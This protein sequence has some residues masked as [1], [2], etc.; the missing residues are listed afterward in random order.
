MEQQPIGG[1][2]LSPQQRR[3][4][5][6]QA[7][8]GTA[9]LMVRCALRVAAPLD[10]GILRAALGDVIARHEIL[11]TTFR[12][13]PGMKLP[14][15]VIADEG[16]VELAAAGEEG[17]PRRLL[18]ELAREPFDPAVPP[19]LRCRLAPTLGN[20]S[21]LLLL[22]P[23]LS[24][25]LASLPR[26]AA[27]I[28]RAYAARSGRPVDGPAAEP[29]QYAD[30][31]EWQNELL[32][33]EETEAGRGFWR[34]LDLSRA[35]T[36]LPMET[37]VAEAG[38][39]APRAW[40]VPLPA[41][42]GDGLAAVAGRVGA[43]PV[44]ILLA[45]WQ[46]FLGRLA[47]ASEMVVGAA[48]EGRKFAELEDAIGPLVRILPV[49][50]SLAGEPA[51][52][53]VAR[54]VSEA[55]D[56]A[57]QWQEYFSWDL[58][59]SR[60]A[61]PAAGVPGL[62]F[63]FELLSPPPEPGFAGWPASFEVLEGDADRFTIKLA[64]RLDGGEGL[65]AE[66]Q[67]DPRRFE[68]SAVARLADGFAT[69]LAAA[70][71]APETRAADLDLLAADDRRL[72]AE[73]NRTAAPLPERCLHELLSEQA[74]RTPDRVAVSANSRELTYAELDARA[75]RLAGHL[76]SLGV[77]P[78]V[79]VGV[80]LERSPELV[81]ALLAVLKAGGAYVP[82]D[83]DYPRE[84]LRFM[85]EDAAA[86]LLLTRGA[87]AP[88]L[89]GAPGRI[90]EVDALA[91]LPA[92]R[93]TRPRGRALPSHLAYVLYTSGS[94]GRPK[95]VMIP[96]RSLVSHMLWMQAS[97]PLD[98]DD[99]VLQRTPFSFDA[100]VWEFYA[101]LLAGACLVL[102]RPGNRLDAGFLIRRIR[103]E[104]VT[105]LQ[106]VPSLLRVLLAHEE[107]AAC[108]S[109][110]RVFSGGEALRP[111]LARRFCET[112]G[113]DLVNLYGPTEATIDSTSHRT[114]PGSETVPIG[115]PIANASIRVLDPRLQ[116]LP[117]LVPGELHIAGA[118]LARGYLDRPALTAGAFLPDPWSD[119]PGG[120]MYRTGDLVRLLPD[121][122][123]EFL[124][125]I[126]DQVKL[127][128][129][130]LE[131]G[132]IEVVL[133][134]HPGVEQAVAVVR[135]DVPGDQRLVAY[136]L[137]PGGGSPPRVGELRAFLGERL[138][139]HMIPATFV[140][141][142]AFP[143]APN[144][145]VDRRQL[146]APSSARPDLEQE[147]VAPRDPDEEILA[148][149][150]S[151]VLG[152]DEIGVRDNFLALGAD[153][154]RSVRVVALAQERGIDLSLQQ[155][156]QHQT[157]EAL[158]EA[159]RQGNGGARAVG[160]EPFSLVAD[161]DLAKLPPGLEDAYPL[162]TLQAGMLYHMQV[163]PA[164]PAYHNVTGF[165]L[166]ARFDREAFQ[167]AVDRAVARH[168][169]LRTAFDMTT[170]GE[171]LQLV[172]P[173]ARLVVVVEDLRGLSRP[174]QDAVVEA[175]VRR[176]KNTPFDL[177]RPPLLRFFVHRL[178]EETFWFTL[179]EC[180]SILDGWSLTSI[181]R[182]VF[183][184]QFR[185]LDGEDLTDEP[186]LTVTFRDFVHQEIRARRSE[187]HR[188]FWEE[189]L[190]GASLLRLPRTLA[191]RPADAPSVANLP[192]EIGSQLSDG[193]VH[194]ARSATVPLKSVCLAAHLKFLAMVTGRTDI[195]TGLPTNGRPEHRDGERIRGLFIN[196]VPFRLE[197]GEWS[198]LDLVKEAF[199]AERRL[200]PYRQYPLAAMR[201]NWDEEP[202]FEV[203]FSFVH[204]HHLDR[205]V[206]RGELE[207]LDEFKGWEATNF[208][209]LV[210]FNRHPPSLDLKMRLYYLP[211][212]LTEEQVTGFRDCFLRIF[213]AMVSNPYAFHSDIDLRD[214]VSPAESSLL[215]ETTHVNDLDQDFSF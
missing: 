41:A 159:L 86:P 179:T 62:P 111:E 128:G 97:F 132:E 205:M 107:F 172:H 94:T 99:R 115:R 32:E 81:L 118:G 108:T 130:R 63:A 191:T 87:L 31:A 70:L 149:I 59:G 45:A 197:M 156:F 139:E 84:R 203:L 173:R 96:H 36:G 158:A 58:V 192:V 79:R 72:L 66:L 174:Q 180:H 145:K 4:W 209:L 38:G 162:S 92:P 154:I 131:L 53:E 116:P 73:V 69:F 47:G 100:S 30:L 65:A 103:E 42:A 152:V 109:L 181:L 207:Y 199:A 1:F 195:L 184:D 140:R 51:F 102:D 12:P 165:L 16:I 8:A 142:K 46:C 56:E 82:L 75:E 93:G 208:P 91:E 13:L 161:A 28:G 90:V 112:L 148:A 24:A 214:A 177:S 194:L 34:R 186:P 80:C 129:F 48:F 10:P 78:D 40:P 164:A 141:L 163:D 43:P 167:T 201:Q 49:R 204:F 133:A 126:N 71:A 144:G 37:A 136:W 98:G 7:G 185:L 3:L 215:R 50:V 22:L 171:P 106:V 6:L 143:L 168:A 54:R 39:F 11:R 153:S 117:A 18:A 113:A 52:Q 127:R 68:E 23:A 166:R 26:L 198:W 9:G 61:G 206:Q 170:Y 190:R 212:E 146:P 182:E 196:T 29:V 178:S 121:G 213:R 138:P 21:L 150:W 134:G 104:G 25:D 210:G 57:H 35:V 135:E 17:E 125:R 137:A 119:E 187:E 95:G 20:G 155:V 77:G 188:A 85:A 76:V 202:L 122:S 2:R 160:S 200:L 151:E 74:G 105:V 120:R 27:E 33:G 14:V 211:A 55:L 44:A 147:L 88:L 5:Q 176:E 193:L 19:L 169:V 83:P 124:G 89:A 60:P 183:E 189:Q 110:R 15:Q 64:T 175:L 114:R 123:L 67:A 101:P 157:I